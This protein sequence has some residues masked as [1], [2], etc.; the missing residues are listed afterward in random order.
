MSLNWCIFS[1]VG[2]KNKH[3]ASLYF[4]VFSCSVLKCIIVKS[5]L[6]S[7]KILLPKKKAEQRGKYFP[8]GHTPPHCQ[9]WQIFSALNNVCGDQTCTELDYIFAQKAWI[10]EKVVKMGKI[11]VKR[12]TLER[13]TQGMKP[14]TVRRNPFSTGVCL[15]YAPELCVSQRQLLFLS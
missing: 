12:W 6:V 13:W 15:K 3:T 10:G 7:H 5:Y 11:T 14:T 8:R 9:Q 2:M 4:Y 1:A